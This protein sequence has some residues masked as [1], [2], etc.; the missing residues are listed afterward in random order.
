MNGILSLTCQHAF[1]TAKVA[2]VK[3]FMSGGDVLMNDE[4]DEIVEPGDTVEADD[5]DW[6][7]N[8]ITTR[9]DVETSGP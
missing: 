6:D 1:V 5:E 2:E 3:E 7:L 9:E 4:P 8:G